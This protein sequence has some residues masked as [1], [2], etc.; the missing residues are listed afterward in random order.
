MRDKLIRL[1][2]DLYLGK[3]DRLTDEKWDYRAISSKGTN[4][5]QTTKH[6]SGMECRRLLASPWSRPPGAVSW[7]GRPLCGEPIGWDVVLCKRSHLHSSG[8]LAVKRE[9]KKK[10]VYHF[11]HPPLSWD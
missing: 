5:V 9:R 3:I 2:V 10:V 1:G 8:H 7:R 11:M 4:A 6:S